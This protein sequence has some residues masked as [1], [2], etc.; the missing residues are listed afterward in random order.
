MHDFCLNRKPKFIT[1]GREASQKDQKIIF[2]QFFNVVIVSKDYSVI[3]DIKVLEAVRNERLH[4]L[5]M[6]T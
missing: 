5:Y 6:H 4:L 3:Q 1:S 2:F